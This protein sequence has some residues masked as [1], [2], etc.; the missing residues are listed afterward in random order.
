MLYREIIAVCSEIHAKHINRCVGQNVEFL[1]VKPHSICINH[2]GL[3][4]CSSPEKKTEFLRWLFRPV[5]DLL[6]ISEWHNFSIHSVCAVCFAS[7]S[8]SPRH[9]EWLTRDVDRNNHS[10]IHKLTPLT[11]GDHLV[12]GTTAFRHTTHSRLSRP[13]TRHPASSDS[14]SNSYTLHYAGSSTVPNLVNQVTTAYATGF[15]VHKLYVLPH[16]VYLC[17]LCGFQNKQ[18]LF[19]YTALTDWFL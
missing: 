12:T 4:C 16:T 10:Q 11:P 8:G 1:D 7:D 5:S 3:K 2:S 9:G 6:R 19:S 17:V 18:R 14:H 13:G 15:N